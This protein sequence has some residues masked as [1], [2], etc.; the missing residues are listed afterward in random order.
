MRDLQAFPQSAPPANPGEWSVGVPGMTYEMYLAAE[1]AKGVLSAG[2]ATRIES[3]DV[4]KIVG[5]ITDAI[6][7]DLERR[8]S[9][10]KSDG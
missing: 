3:A 2:A 1:V 4:A 9:E 6:I 5:Q 8:N 7:D 10:R